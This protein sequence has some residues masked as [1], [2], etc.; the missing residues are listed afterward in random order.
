MFVFSQGEE[1]LFF[2]GCV[3]DDVDEHPISQFAGKVS[4]LARLKFYRAGDESEEGVVF[5]AFDVFAGMVFGAALTDDDVAY[6]YRLTAIYFHAEA[7][8]NGITA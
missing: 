8:G 7:F 4:H 3:R 1:R 2:F 6:F 5:A